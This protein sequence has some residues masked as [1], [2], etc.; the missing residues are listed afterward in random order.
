M[1]D[2]RRGATT[3]IFRWPIHDLILPM[4]LTLPVARCSRG[5]CRRTSPRPPRVRSLAAAP[6]PATWRV[7]TRRGTQR[8]L[9][10]NDAVKHW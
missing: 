6:A 1:L 5:H 10:G 4:M 3:S 2:V 9:K 7:A 8:T